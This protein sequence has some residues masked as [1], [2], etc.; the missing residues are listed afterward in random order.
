MCVECDVGM[1]LLSGTCHGDVVTAITH[2]NALADLVA[3]S[4]LMTQQAGSG[5]LDTGFPVASVC[6]NDPQADF[7]RVYFLDS[8]VSP[9]HV[10]HRLV[11]WR[12]ECL[13]QLHPRTEH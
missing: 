1:Q 13:S 11:C 9:L 3:L 12:R 8:R 6:Y 7:P 2:G 10:F 4:E 5:Q